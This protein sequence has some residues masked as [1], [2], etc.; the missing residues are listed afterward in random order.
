M[1]EHVH[2]PQHTWGGKG[3]LAGVSPLLLLCGS[4]HQACQLNQPRSISLANTVIF[5]PITSHNTLKRN[6]RDSHV[7][8]KGQNYMTERGTGEYA[9]VLI[10][11]KRPRTGYK[12]S[13]TRQIKLRRGNCFLQRP[14]RRR[15]EAGACRASTGLCPSDTPGFYSW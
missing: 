4:T 2:R 7:N 11:R 5:K 9:H 6:L 10:W 8:T 15:V 3:Q 14:L 13:H 1:C 12:N